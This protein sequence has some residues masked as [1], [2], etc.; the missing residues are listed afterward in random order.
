MGNMLPWFQMGQGPDSTVSSWSRLPHPLLVS[1]ILLFLWHAAY[2]FSWTLDDPFI[3]FRYASFLNRGQGLVFNPGERVEGYSNFLWTLWVALGMKLGVQAFCWAKWSGLCMGVLNLLLLYRLGVG[4]LPGDLDRR[5]LGAGMAVLLTGGSFWWGLWMMGGLE[6]PL[7]VLL[8]LWAVVRLLREGDGSKRL[9]LAGV[10]VGLLGL[11]RPEGPLWA[12]ALLGGMAYAYLRDRAPGTRRRLLVYGLSLAAIGGGYAAFKLA[13]Y[14]G[15]LPNT[16]YAKMGERWIQF[17]HGLLYLANALTV[18]AGFWL[19]EE[20]VPV[21]P[22]HL[23]LPGAWIS[24]PL[25]LALGVAALFFFRRSSARVELRAFLL[26]GLLGS[27]GFILYFGGDWMAGFRF[28]IPILPLG[29]LML[30]GWLLAGKGRVTTWL[31]PLALLFLLGSAVFVQKAYALRQIPWIR[32]MA[33]RVRCDLPGGPLLN[34]VHWIRTHVPK[35]SLIAISEAGVIPFH[36]PEYRFL[37][38]LG[39]TDPHVGRLEG[40]LHVKTDPPYIFAR[41][42]RLLVLI[43]KKKGDRFEGFGAFQAFFESPGLKRDYFLRKTLQR[44]EKDDFLLFERRER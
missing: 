15:L 9:P 35:G 24:L 41:K 12:L 1:G 43:G 5:R 16:F 33:Y 17:Q 31:A 23:L 37:D 39:L 20:R 32:S 25:A 42:P 40:E 34:V 4:V 30:S 11:T 36:C 8:I 7:F 28:L 2:A 27:L 29:W 6:V 21:D 3:S 18:S 13:Y 19:G 44:G 26:L 14:G 10:L 38:Y 22:Q